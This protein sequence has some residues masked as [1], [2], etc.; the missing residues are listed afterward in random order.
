MSSVKKQNKISG[1]QKKHNNNGNTLQTPILNFNQ[2]TKNNLEVL[3]DLQK[4]TETVET[5]KSNFQQTY[6]IPKNIVTTSNSTTFFENKQK[7]EK[8]KSLYTESIFLGKTIQN[9][10]QYKIFEK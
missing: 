4:T 1:H 9:N 5:T 2:N 6:N 8:F 10:E 3:R 7:E